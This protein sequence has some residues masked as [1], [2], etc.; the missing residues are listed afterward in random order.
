MHGGMG[1]DHTYLHPWLDPLG[2][3][4]H[5]VYYDHR[6]NGRSGRPPIETLTYEQYAADANGLREHLGFD[7]VAVVGHSAGGFV[8]LK[9]A[10]LHPQF[11][12]HLILVDTTPAWDYE[13]EILANAVRKGV[14]PEMRE[15]YAHAATSDADYSHRFKVLSPLYFHKFDPEVADRLFGKTVF[16]VTAA[17]RDKENLK[18]FN[19]TSSLH[20]IEAPTLI[21][22]GR[23]DFICPPSQAERMHKGIPE[24]D[25]VVFEKS[26]HLPYAEEPDAFFST[27]RNWIKQR[28]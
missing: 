2:D 23:H 8:A 27:V 13:K 7:K 20:E 28:S 3:V 10:I 11:L 15:V 25:I 9:Y 21:L 1:F 4:L 22:V 24:S 14:T 6:G 16:C 19:V 12:S 5:L 17:K 26:G 18:S